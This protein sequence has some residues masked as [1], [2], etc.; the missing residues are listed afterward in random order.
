MLSLDRKRRFYHELQ[1]YYA[2]GRITEARA[3]W[4]RE[5]SGIVSHRV[6]P[7]VSV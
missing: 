2:L 5:R 4:A 6:P 1:F 7:G 3:T